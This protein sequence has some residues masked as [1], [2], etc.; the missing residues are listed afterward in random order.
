MNFD[1]ENKSYNRYNNDGEQRPRRPRVGSYNREGGERPYRSSY[2]SRGG[3]GDRPQRPRFN[4][5]D[6]E[7]RPYRPRTNNYHTE[8][9]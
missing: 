4:A 6:G 9:Q 7:Q 2:N 5:E 1:N 8:E 3:Y